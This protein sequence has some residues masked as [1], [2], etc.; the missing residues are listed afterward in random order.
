MI[1]RGIEKSFVSRL[2]DHKVLI[3]FGARQV[4]K[5]TFLNQIFEEMESVLWLNGDDLEVRILLENVN[6]QTWKILIGKHKY[7]IIDEAQRIENIGLKTKLLVDNKL[8]KVV[9]SGSSSFD[10][11]NKLNEPLTGRKWE[12]NLFPF[13][14]QELAKHTNVITEKSLLENRLVFGAYPEVV[15]NQGEEKSILTTLS[16]SY[17]YKDIFSWQGIRKPEKLK[18]LLMALAFQLGNEV[19]YN[20]LGKTIGLDNQSVE[21][22]IDLL[23]KNFIVF[24]LTSFSRN[25]R[26]ELTS[27]RKIYFWD[28]GIR[29]AI[30]AQFQ[31]IPLRQDVGNLFENYFIAERIKYNRN[32]GF[33][34]NYYFWRTHDQQEI[35]LIEEVDGKLIAY[36]IKWN[37]TKKVRFSKTF[38]NNYENVETHVVNPNN[39]FTYLTS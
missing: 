31:P 12:Y 29:N 9:L 10:L 17:L 23:E 19:S 39:Y 14:F 18:L 35:D 4:G 27:K 8:V 11:A 22:Y 7:L 13:G 28:L 5:T 2:D 32:Q 37:A 16:D 20:E 30:I 24:R 1:K 25:L 34:S 3:V 26:K 33:F 21:S 38:T 6:T 36:E 15:L